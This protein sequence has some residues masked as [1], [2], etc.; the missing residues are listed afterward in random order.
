MKSY[1]SHIRIRLGFCTLGFLLA[2]AVLSF[3]AWQLQL[4]SD[5]RIAQL[6]QKQLD[7]HSVLSSQRGTI[8]DT[9]GR[10]LAVSLKAPSIFLD[11]TQV[12]NPKEVSKK[13]SRILRKPEQAIEKQVKKKSRRFIWVK[14]QTDPRVVEQIQSLNLSGVFTTDEWTRMYPQR[15]LGAQI[16]GAVGID[17]QGLEGIE[18]FYDDFLRGQTLVI[19]TQKDARGRSIFSYERSIFHPGRGADLFLTIDSRIQHVTETELA[20]A[21][22]MSS[23]KSAMAVVMDPQDGKILAMANYPPTNS[24]RM[25]QRAPSF[26]RNRPVQEVF[27][28][29][30]TFKIFTLAAALESNVISPEQ[31]FLCKKGSLTFGRKIIRN[32]IEKVWLDP[33]GILKFSNNVGVARIGLDLGPERFYRAIN[34]FGFHA[35]TG[36]DFPAEAR[37][38]LSDSETWQPIDLANIAFGQGIGVTAIQMLSSMSMIA[39]GGYS[40]RPYLV[41]RATFSN[42]EQIDFQPRFRPSRVFSPRTANLITN[43]MEAV[44][45][46]D[47]TG[48]FAAIEGYRVAGKTGTAQV[49]DPEAKTYSR[50]QIISSFMGFAP[51]SRPRL[52]GIFIFE[53]PKSEAQGGALAAPVFQKVISRALIYLGISR[54]RKSTFKPDPL[55]LSKA[56]VDPT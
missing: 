30:S 26:L 10:E 27:E 45:E 53:K 29:G 38:L 23:A 15:E 21:A 55:L 51:V 43:W 56:K 3:R 46:P 9:F 42:G 12:R 52:A 5:N 20:K 39:N 8:F 18:R 28:P 17:G 2:F 16:L 48:H 31:I 34:R 24:N 49:F 32:T 36:I 22:E 47:G 54:D 13:L 4:V 1:D 19:R 37:G 40:V 25:D 41:K 11:P 35:K 50:D 44:V 14:R 33:R 7:H 6:E